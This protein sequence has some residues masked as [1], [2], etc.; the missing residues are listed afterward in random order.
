MTAIGREVQ[1]LQSGMHSIGPSNGSNL[2]SKRSGLIRQ[3]QAE[4]EMCAQRHLPTTIH[5]A[6][7]NRQVAKLC[8]TDKGNA[9]EHDG[10][11]QWNAEVSSRV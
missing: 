9:G 8:F 10:V 7:E 11:G 2:H 4:L 3:E 5:S 6:T 1:E